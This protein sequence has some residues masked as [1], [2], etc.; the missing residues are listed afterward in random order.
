MMMVMMM[1]MMMIVISVAGDYQGY[2]CTSSHCKSCELVMP[3][4]YGKLNGF[5]PVINQ[6]M[7]STYMECRDQRVVALSACP[8]GLVFDMVDRKCVDTISEGLSF[9][10]NPAFLFTLFHIMIFSSHYECLHW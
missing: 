5:Y 9:L 10:I 3:S 1:M 2:K 4:C 8:G 7:T 6:E